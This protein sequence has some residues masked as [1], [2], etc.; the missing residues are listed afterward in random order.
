MSLT[1]SLQIP[2]RL[3]TLPYWSN[4]PFLIFG[5]S[6]IKNAGLDLYG[7]QRFKQQQYGTSGVERINI[8]HLLFAIND[9]ENSTNTLIYYWQ[10]CFC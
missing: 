4:P 5:M 8:E 1:I 2:L 9:R 3:Y 10:M 6:K 7:A